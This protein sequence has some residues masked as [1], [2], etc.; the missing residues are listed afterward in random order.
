MAERSRPGVIRISKGLARI[1]FAL[2][3]NRFFNLRPT[4]I[5]FA[6]ATNP[7]C[8]ERA[9]ASFTMA[10]YAFKRVPVG[11]DGMHRSQRRSLSHRPRRPR[12][13]ALGLSASPSFLALLS[14]PA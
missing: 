8:I 4:S 2:E 14:R 6:P 13:T 11:D 12:H 1:H 7:R 3:A 9:K 5:T 10:A